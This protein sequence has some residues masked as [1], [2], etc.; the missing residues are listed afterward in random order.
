MRAA[1]EKREA[2]RAA[3]Y[4]KAKFRRIMQAIHRGFYIFEN[5]TETVT[6]DGKQYK[7]E[8]KE[9]DLLSSRGKFYIHSHMEPFDYAGGLCEVIKIY[10]IISE[11]VGLYS[12]L[13]DKTGKNICV[14][15]I[16]KYR[17][18]N[19]DHDIFLVVDWDDEKALFYAGF[20]K[21]WIINTVCEVVVLKIE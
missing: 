19:K 11:T 1:T 6:I 4:K 12:G 18:A 20:A 9:G 7:G 10:P 5:G 3:L 2:Q 15:D 21:L 14:N 17:P 16:V 8:W 13:P